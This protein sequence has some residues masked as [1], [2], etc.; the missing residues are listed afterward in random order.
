MARP[1]PWPKPEKF[2]ILTNAATQAGAGTVSL[3]AAANRA[4]VP[5]LPDI[6]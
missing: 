1:E 3:F 5:V 2:G 4:V 6:R